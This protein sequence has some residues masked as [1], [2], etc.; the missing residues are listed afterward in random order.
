MTAETTK[1]YDILDMETGRLDRRIFVD[2]AI[3]QQEL[4]KIFGR[5]WLM[6]A[7]ESLIPNPGDFFLSY[8]GEDPVIVTRDQDMKMHV[9]LNMCRHRGN[10]VVRA[11]DG[12]ASN[13]MCTYHGWTFG[14]DGTLNH[15][16]GEQE[17]FYGNLE[18]ERLALFEAR[19]DSY[20]GIIFACWDKEAPSLEDYLGDAR[21]YLD[22][23]FNR[24]EN[25]MIAHGPQKWIEPCN[26]K[27]P[28]DNCSDNYHVPISHY[29][30]AYVA[31]KVR[32]LPMQSME[33]QLANPNPSHHVFVNGHSLTFRIRD[34][35]AP[36]P[37]RRGVT[38]ENKALF[39]EWDE[40]SATEAEKRLGFER[41]R[42]LQLGNHSL[43][44]NTVLGFRL[45]HPR[46]PYKTEFWHFALVPKDAP[47]PVRNASQNATS[48]FNG[49][50]G[51][52]EQDDIDNWRQVTEASKS[53]IARRLLAELSMG[54][55]HSGPSEEWPGDHSE[56][57][58]SENNQRNF[59]MRW[60]EFM[61]AEGWR[62]I[63][64]DPPTAKYEGTATF[65]GPSEA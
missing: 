43:F 49:A 55:G 35:N 4:E 3:Y 2:E 1:K 14:S 60:M 27:A 31:N 7:H 9:L 28:V 32:G 45:A 62:N 56:R 37:I 53:P 24:F 58:I 42:E 20:A 21:W 10:R 26:W 5:A 65:Q 44:P 17:A 40:I 52:F 48:Q 29:S 46:G 15:V 33:Q 12:N 25:G 22:S 51:I 54:L 61:N 30:S 38:E 11:D 59:Y 18:K 23:N 34:A 8:M 19:C 47:E 13:F 39:D 50:A 64:L 6:V 63:H 41:A 57:Y 36:R 16:P